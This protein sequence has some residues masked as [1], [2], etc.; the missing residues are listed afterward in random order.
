MTTAKTTTKPGLALVTQML[1]VTIPAI[2]LA[3]SAFA[4]GTMEGDLRPAASDAEIE[5]WEFATTVQTIAFGVFALALILSL[6][7]SFRWPR[8]W[9]MRRAATTIMLVIL[10]GGGVFV[11]A[12]MVGLQN[13]AITTTD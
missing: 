4:M 13:F 12:W 11:A 10:V 9:R 7:D 8:G 2:L 6:I 5:R 3:V 1:L